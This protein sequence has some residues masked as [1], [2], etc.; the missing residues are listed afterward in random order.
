MNRAENAGK[1]LGEGESIV[2]VVQQVHR[3]LDTFADARIQLG[4]C[5]PRRRTGG[6][7]ADSRRRHR[8]NGL[9]HA[10][11]KFH[12]TKLDHTLLECSVLSRPAGPSLL[13]GTSVNS[14]SAIT[15]LRGRTARACIQ[16]AAER[17]SELLTRG[18]AHCTRATLAQSKPTACHRPAAD[19]MMAYRVASE[20]PAARRP[21]RP[22]RG[23]ARLP[24][25]ARS[26]RRRPA[27][28]ALPATYSITARRSRR[29]RLRTAVGLATSGARQYK[30]RSHAR[31]SR[32]VDPALTALTKRS[33]RRSGPTALLDACAS[34]RRGGRSTRCARAARSLARPG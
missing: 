6:T 17:Y 9:S 3:E 15:L 25:G 5:V 22:R 28:E 10:S 2:A 31:R 33:G 8:T 30:L 23:G 24:K 29:R 7:S 13:H 21:R 19:S 12:Y 1:T 27:A 34:E 4:A 20:I 32:A 11:Q 26:T 18:D 16:A 14:I